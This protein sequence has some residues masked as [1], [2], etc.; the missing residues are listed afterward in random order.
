MYVR[1]RI[2]SYMVML[3][4]TLHVRGTMYYYLSPEMD[5]LRAGHADE[6]AN[7][8]DSMYNQLLMTLSKVAIHISNS[9]VEFMK[10]G[11]P[12]YDYNIDFLSEILSWNPVIP[13]AEE[14]TEAA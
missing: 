13:E 11:M 5:K 14:L 1:D 2:T 12:G 6:V 10:M 8:T 9:R 3:G 7:L 4:Y